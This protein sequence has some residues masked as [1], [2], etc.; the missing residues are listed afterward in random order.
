MPLTYFL[1][2]RRLITKLYGITDSDIG[3][4]DFWQF[5]YTISDINDEYESKK[6]D[7]TSINQKV[8]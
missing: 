4:W 3:K 8:F 7:K 2:N 5:Q 1:K 6:I